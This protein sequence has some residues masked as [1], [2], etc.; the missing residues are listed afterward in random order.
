MS[1]QQPTKHR[2]RGTAREE[3]LWMSYPREVAL[4]HSNLHLAKTMPRCDPRRGSPTGLGS[5]LTRAGK[6]PKSVFC[7]DNPRATHTI[8]QHKS[9]GDGDSTELAI[10]VVLT[11][12]SLTRDAHPVMPIALREAVVS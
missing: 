10:A 1:L 5:D 11:Q 7:G 8:Y 9:R 12:V 2:S 4:Q 3:K 6:P